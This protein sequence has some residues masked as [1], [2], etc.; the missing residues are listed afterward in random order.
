M[1]GAVVITHGLGTVYAK[2]GTAAAVLVMDAG[3]ASELGLD[4]TIGDIDPERLNVN[5]GAMV[6]ER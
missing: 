1:A 3:V 2:Y 4:A 5:G 6:L